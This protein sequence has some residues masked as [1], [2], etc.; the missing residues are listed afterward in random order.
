LTWTV[1]E[2]TGK[3]LLAGIELQKKAQLS[4]WDAL[5][6]EAAIEAGC[7]ILY[8]EDLNAGQRIGPL[9]IVNPFK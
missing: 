9:T 5:V 1:V 6:V 2:N 3:L 8:S 7:D 4:F